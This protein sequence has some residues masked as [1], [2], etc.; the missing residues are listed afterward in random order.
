M[1]TRE[2]STISQLSKVC[3]LAIIIFSLP[4]TQ[5]LTVNIGF[6]LKISEIFLLI[7]MAS[8]ISAKHSS[9]LINWREIFKTPNILFFILF[10]IIIAYSTILNLFWNFDYSLTN[11][12]GSRFGYKF[13]SVLRFCYIFLSFFAFFVIYY[14]FERYHESIL[15]WWV[16]GAI[17]AAI[18]SMYLV[19]SSALKIPMIL[20]PGMEDSPRTTDFGIIRC[21][22]FLEG[23]YMG[24]YLFVSGV[25]AHHLNWKKSYFFLFFS[26]IFTFSSGAFVALFVYVLYYQIR[27]IKWSAKYLLYFLIFTI[28]FSLSLYFLFSNKAVSSVFIG[29]IF[30]NTTEITGETFSKIQ[31]LAFSDM[32]YRIGNDNLFGVGPSNYALHSGQYFDKI[33]WLPIKSLAD[34]ADFMLIGFKIIPNNVYLEIYAEYGIF[35]LLIFFLFIFQILKASYAQPKLHGGLI[36]LLLIFLAFPSFILLFVWVFLAI[37]LRE[38]SK[39]AYCPKIIRFK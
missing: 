6:P 26:M 5:A 9:I 3:I 23:N 31:R 10:F 32:A 29:K 28:L 11:V 35:A 30:G 16:Y 27:I 4:F 18:Y 34:R 17:C 12:E 39:N 37:V 36:G 2:L 24:A 38:S 25:L 21:G 22:T 7:L 8:A 13:D 15:R 19:V 20:L 14:K 1:Q 33:D